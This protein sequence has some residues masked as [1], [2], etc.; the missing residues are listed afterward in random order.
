MEA[1]QFVKLRFQLN[2]GTPS[3]FY[4]VA[5]CPDPKTNLA[6]EFEFCI[7][8]VD[9]GKVSRY[10]TCDN[11]PQSCELLTAAG[12]F[13]L[14]TIVSGMK[15]FMVSAGVGVIAFMSAARSVSLMA[16]TNMLNR[17]AHLTLIHSVRS[18]NLPY[19]EE[20]VTIAT[21]GGGEGDGNASSLLNFQLCICVSGK[22]DVDIAQRLLS[23]NNNKSPKNVEIRQGHVDKVLLQNYLN[24]FDDD[25]SSSPPSPPE[26]SSV[27]VYACGPRN[28][29]KMVR[30]TF[31]KDFSHPRN[32]I[33]LEFFDL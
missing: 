1:G 10:L 24:K 7:K 29:Q 23:S 13:K 20:L 5:S 28:F 8:K 4:S 32:L 25:D 9:G 11:P 2:D 19:I 3:R 12:S 27:P 33:H 26:R 14:P 17:K 22:L 15:R 6:S 18:L 21:G 16:K 31:L 30:E